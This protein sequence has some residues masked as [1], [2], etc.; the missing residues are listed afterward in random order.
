MDSNPPD[1]E[2]LHQHTHTHRHH[3]NMCTQRCVKYIYI[4]SHAYGENT[5]WGVQLSELV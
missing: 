3:E 5:H 1:W 4:Y 2:I